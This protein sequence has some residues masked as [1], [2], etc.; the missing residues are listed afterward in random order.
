MDMERTE[1]HKD[2]N[3]TPD[4]IVIS[5]WG[6]DL[7]AFRN[8]STAISFD[9][10]KIYYGFGPC[11]PPLYEKYPDKEFL[12]FRYYPQ[13]NLLSLWVYTPDTIISQLLEFKSS[14]DSMDEKP[15]PPTAKLVFLSK[16]VAVSCPLDEI[17]KLTTIDDNSY[18]RQFHVMSPME[19][20]QHSDREEL[21]RLSERA[22]VANHGTLD[23]AEY[24]LLA[25]EE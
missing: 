23:I 14:Y 21:Y 25:Y 17:P 24:H 12:D 2:D 7:M 19:K 22:W 3:L 13:E 18:L 9:G 1:L 10:M 6:Y 8:P 11:H 15:F 20:P 16:G 5:S 4:R